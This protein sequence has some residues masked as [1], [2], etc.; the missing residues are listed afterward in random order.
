MSN[1]LLLIG[2][3]TVGFY[4]ISKKSK[5]STSSSPKKTSENETG[6]IITDCSSIKLIDQEKFAK[7]FNTI[8]DETI[9]SKQIYNLDPTDLNTVNITIKEVLKKIDSKC[10]NLFVNKNYKSKEQLLTTYIF[11]LV[12][13]QKY[14]SLFF[15]TN[16]WKKYFGTELDLSNHLQKMINELETKAKTDFAKFKIKIEDVAKEF[17]KLLGI[18]LGKSFG[19]EPS[20]LQSPKLQINDV[21]DFNKEVLGAPLDKHVL[22]DFYADWCVPCSIMFEMLQTLPFEFIENINTQFLRLNIDLNPELM[23]KYNITG[24]PHLIIFKNGAPIGELKG[25]AASKELLMEWIKN[26]K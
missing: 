11:V 25:L 21:K 16:T 26:P 18:E 2:L 14:V 6:I 12:I 20:D 1:P 17:E 8:F 22:V 9:K 4:V 3:A 19:L 5:V 24:I 10:Y 7:Y 13:W 15:D 23:K